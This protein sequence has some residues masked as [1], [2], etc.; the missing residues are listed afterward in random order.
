M[1][2]LQKFQELLKKLFQFESSDLD[3]GVYRILNYKRT[4]IEKFITDDLRKKVDES[5]KKHKGKRFDSV[6]SKLEEARKRVIENLGNNAFT[7]SGELKEQFK[8]TPAGKEFLSVK[9]QHK[10]IEKLDKIQSQVFNDL[11]NFFSLYYQDGDFVPQYR[12]SIKGHKYAIPY[13]GEEV[14]LYWANQNQYYIKTGILFRDYTFKADEYKVIFRIAEAKEELGSNKA[15]KE[16]FFILDKNN[17]VEI[18]DK[19]LIIRFE[20]RELT[21]PEVTK[22]DVSGGSNSSKQDKINQK[23]FDKIF[24]SIKD[25]KIKGSLSKVKNEK[26]ILLYHLNRFSAKNTRD[27][28]IHKN[29]KKFL[30]EQLD[31]FIKSE[32]IS[33][34]TIENEQYLDKHITRAK[35]VREIATDIIDFLSQIEDFQKKLWEKK[36]FVLKTEYVITTDRIP[37]VFYDEIFKNKEQKKE[38]KELG[39]EIPDKSK[40]LKNRFLPV[41]TKYFSPEFKEKLLESITVEK[42]L[43]DF[44]NG[45]LIKSENWQALNLLINKYKEKVKT[46]YIDPPYNT[47]ND[48]FLYRDD[49]KTSSWISMLLDRLLIAKKL[50]LDNGISFVSIANNSK[51]YKESYKLGLILDEIFE[52]RF[53]DIIWKR[54]NASGSYVISDITEVHEY[55]LTFGRSKSYIFTNI[56][57]QDKISEFKNKDSKGLFKWHDLVIH[58]YTKEQRQNMWFEVIYNPKTNKLDFDRKREDI[59][60]GE[61]II[62][63][64]EDGTSVY[65]MVKKSMEEVY[66]RGIIEAINENGKYKLKIKKYLYNDYGIINGEPLKSIL[67]NADLPWKIGGTSDA[68]K[69]LKNLFGIAFD[70]AKPSDLIKLFIYISM[71]KNEYILDFFAG[72]ASTMQA[73]M[74]INYEDKGNRKYILIEIANHFDKIIIPRL[75]KLCYSLNWK[76]SE[77]LNINGISQFTKYLTMEQYEDV[78][79]NLE[80]IENKDAQELFK[81]DYLL[82]YFIDFETRENSSLLNID[83]LKTPFEYKI[84]INFEEVGEPKETIVDIPETFNYLLGLKVNKFKSRLLNSNKYVFIL[85]EKESKD[86]AIVWRNYKNEWE[87]EDYKND[88]EFIL[89]ELKDWNPHIIYINGNSVLTTKF[90]DKTVEIKYIEPEFKKLMF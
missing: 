75:K 36:K 63:P 86:V 12:Y 90:F 74:K 53:A 38:W 58:Q 89:N 39:F 68:T 54:R 56:L 60:K 35:V 73:I 3:F 9:E 16:R 11:Y 49:Y 20:Y 45:L 43:D 76:E 64:S 27:Y 67:E 33:I 31:Y 87:D 40:D 5:F 37:E 14:K 6:K 7:N 85:G 70:T 77:P 47:G 24:E 42:N 46:I 44:L 65:T 17:P 29:L 80:F 1:D 59:K 10:E 19:N 88:K 52:K 41:D 61:I 71:F 2:S 25:I 57:N 15:T 84:K 78:L 8:D 18:S 55:I 48:G 21:N 4:A 81:D 23:S 26:P 28:F 13:N 32:V 30:S 79:D 72:S 51:Y 50:L 34:E 22:Y 69:E 62:N 66:K 83:K 82:K